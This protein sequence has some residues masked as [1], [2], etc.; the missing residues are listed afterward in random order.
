MANDE[1]STKWSESLQF[2]ERRGKCAR[3]MIT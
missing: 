3:S 1:E 2:L